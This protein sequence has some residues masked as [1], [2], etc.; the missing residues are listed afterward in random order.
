MAESLPAHCSPLSS[1][2]DWREPRW[3]CKC[4]T[5][6][7]LWRRNTW[8]SCRRCLIARSRSSTPPLSPSRLTM[9]V[10]SP[11]S[12]PSVECSSSLN[13]LRG[14][15]KLATGWQFGLTSSSP[16]P[17]TVRRGHNTDI[18][19]GYFPLNSLLPQCPPV[20]SPGLALLLRDHVL[21]LPSLGVTHSPHHS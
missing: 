13:L 17:Q 1:G 9:S 21:R 16:L 10:T 11:W 3:C 12:Q 18:W 14:E 5:R 19:P 7:P 6:P 4:I 8:P 20:L 15:Q 2:A